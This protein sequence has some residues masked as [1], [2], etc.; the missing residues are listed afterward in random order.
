VIAGNQKKRG[1]RTAVVSKYLQQA[2]PEVLLRVG[3]VEDIA[4]TQ[5][6]VNG[7]AAGGRWENAGPDANLRCAGASARRLQALRRDHER[8]LKQPGHDWGLVA[9]CVILFAP[10]LIDLIFSGFERGDALFQ[11]FRSGG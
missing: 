6:G 10:F 3:V 4:G 1:L 2:L 11:C 7:V 8:R 9:K 5:D